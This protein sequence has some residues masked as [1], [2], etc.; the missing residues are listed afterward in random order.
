MQNVAY[1][2]LSDQLYSLTLPCSIYS[3]LKHFFASINFMEIQL[4]E[5]M[6]SSISS[7][8]LTHCIR[9][10]PVVLAAFMHTLTYACLSINTAQQ[11]RVTSPHEIWSIQLPLDSFV[12]RIVSSVFLFLNCVLIC[13]LPCRPQMLS[14]LVINTANTN[15]LW[16]KIEQHTHCGLDCF[17]L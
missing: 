12:L 2:F 4:K 15:G 6:T 9:S 11:A 5:D 3:F 7:F 13:L 1:T 8:I 10:F 16:A 14:S 17:P